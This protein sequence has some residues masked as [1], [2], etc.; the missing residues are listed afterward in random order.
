MTIERL[1]YPTEESSV[2]YIKLVG[3]PY[4]KSIFTPK[5]KEDID[6]NATLGRLA[7]NTKYKERLVQDILDVEHCLAELF[8]GDGFYR[9]IDRK[10]K[11]GANLTFNE[12]F[13]LITFV[14]AALNKPLNRQISSRIK[15]LGSYETHLLQA[16]ALLSA[17]S[18]KESYI[19]LT[20]EEIAGMV[21]ATLKLDT[22]IRINSPGEVL[23][24][25][26][27]GGDKGY[28]LENGNSKLFSISTLS[29]IALAVDIPVHKHHS[30][31][32]ISKVAGQS[33]IEAHGARS[34]FHSQEAFES[35]FS[36]TGLFMSSCHDTRTLH[37]LSHLLKGE[38]INHIIGPLSFTISKDSPVQA[39]IG[40]NEKVHPQI[41]VDV[42]RILNKR[43]FQRYGNSAV[44][45]GTDLEEVAASLLSP[46][47]Y[48]Q[49]PSARH[50]VLID[51]VAPPPFVTIASFLVHGENVGTYALYP[52]DFYPDDLLQQMLLREITIQ[53]EA[54]EILRCNLL[55][56]SGQD[57]PKSLYLAM[58]IGLG[59][60]VHSTLGDKDA[61]DP[62]VK[63][64]NRD[65]LRK[66][67]RRAL[68]ILQKGLALQKLQEYITI[69]Q[70]YAGCRI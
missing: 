20:A 9:L 39:L 38:T 18:A 59:L 43:G 46:E 7:I 6:C 68:D 17:M 40:V 15:N 50:H 34:D 24:L 29:A 58:T 37:T 36:E 25:G 52:E 53:N 48:Q 51:E 56:L 47:D 61:L 70:K 8:E 63:R 65:Y 54:D 55:A 1:V 66:C 21:A 27:M 22:I 19:G 16:T 31:P 10:L 32:N 57:L 30:Y 67:T 60:F 3:E 12:A 13:S 42:L 64:V 2:S 4:Q 14:C 45:C 28:P 62:A 41:M 44:Y 23:S 69:T 11:Q 35:V 5:G 33:A 26:G 49:D